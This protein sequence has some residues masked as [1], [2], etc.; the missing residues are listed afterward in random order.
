MKTHKIRFLNV[1]Y[2]SD[3][4]KTLMEK[5]ISDEKNEAKLK[6]ENTWSMALN[7]DEIREL[8]RIRNTRC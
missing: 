4:H 6:D 3:L 7:S 8:K 2:D 5:K 1:P